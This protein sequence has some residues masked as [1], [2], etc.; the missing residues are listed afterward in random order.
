MARNK[1]ALASRVDEREAKW[2]GADAARAKGIRAYIE[3]GQALAELTATGTSQEEIGERYDMS[4]PA[5]S[6]AIQVGQDKR[7]IGISN[8]NNSPKS[9]FTIYLLT[10]LDDAGFAEL[11]KPKTRQ[12]DVLEYKKR[13]AAPKEASKAES[14]APSAPKPTS[15]ASSGPPPAPGKILQYGTAAAY[16]EGGEG[17]APVA[18]EPSTLVTSDDQTKLIDHRQW[19]IEFL[20]D[21]PEETVHHLYRLAVELSE[22]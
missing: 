12:V 2:A 22:D 1:A 8:T 18:S 9:E 15:A 3:F 5:I 13:L 16:A 10:T 17:S 7:L 14:A 6:Q 20:Q 11:A 19:L 21:C 4:Q